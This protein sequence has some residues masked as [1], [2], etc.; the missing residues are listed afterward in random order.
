MA[1]WWRACRAYVNVE[2][3]PVTLAVLL[4]LLLMQMQQAS[5]HQAYVEHVRKMVRMELELAEKEC[6]RQW[7]R[8][9]RGG[10]GQQ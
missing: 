4:L 8:A 7:W 9:Y 6:G 5:A 10:V 3:W 2:E 1:W